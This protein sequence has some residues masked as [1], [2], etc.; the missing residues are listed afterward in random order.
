MYLFSHLSLS[1]L[2][3][4]SC[5]CS[6]S[7]SPTLDQDNDSKLGFFT[8]IYQIIVL[9]ISRYR[10]VDNDEKEFEKFEE[11]EIF[12]IVFDTSLLEIKE[13]LVEDLEEVVKETCYESLEEPVLEECYVVHNIMFD[14]S[15]FEIKENPIEDLEVEGMKEACLESLQEGQELKQNQGKISDHEPK[16]VQPIGKV[17]RLK[18]F[19]Q[20][21]ENFENMSSK[22][23]DKDVEP[24]PRIIELKK[25][26]DRKGNSPSIR[27]ESKE[28]AASKMK[29]KVNSSPN[30]VGENVA[31]S[32]K[33]H[34]DDSCLK[35]KE[36]SQKSANL[37]S[38]RKEKE[39][40]KTLACKL[41]EE[42][43]NNNVEGSEGM[44][45]L[46]EKNEIEYSNNK[47]NNINTNVVKKGEIISVEYKHDDDDDD[48]EGL[49]EEFDENF[50]D[51]QLCCMQALK[52]SVGKMKL[53]MRRPN[54]LKIS[55]TLKGFGWLHHVTKHNNKKGYH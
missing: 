50:T 37:G 27:I 44:D 14:T 42:R 54:L 12:Q 47:S 36:D 5:L 9:E 13:N 4:F 1:L 48:D 30:V 39:W 25:V 40:R 11:L 38:M 2:F 18:Q 6:L 24:L 31:G 23:E 49:D 22:R 51:G 52:F 41:F 34:G 43:H 3:F 21:M 45:M 7:L 55:K 53:G 35:V 33:I 29:V 20:E 46:W 19:W 15:N 32:N 26:E 17:K 8:S 28:I 10:S 16:I